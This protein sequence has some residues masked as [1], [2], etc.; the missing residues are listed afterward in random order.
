MENGR[1]IACFDSLKVSMTNT[2]EVHSGL[3]FLV[4]S[5]DKHCLQKVLS[6]TLGVSQIPELF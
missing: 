1:V 6:F 3:F 2:R 5:V 4:C